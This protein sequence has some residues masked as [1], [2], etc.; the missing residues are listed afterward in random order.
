MDLTLS[1]LEDAARA[2]DFSG[3]VRVERPDG[4]IAEFASGHAD[5]ANKRANNLTTRFAVAS[6]VKGL[7]ALTVM[8]LVES[9]ELT[10]DATLTSIVGRG[11]LQVDE[12]VTIDHLL[13]HRSGVGDYIDE[14]ADGDVDDHVLD[15]LSVHTLE[16]PRDYLELLNAPEQK[17]RPGEQFAYNNS[18]FV[19]LSLVIEAI[20][21]SYHEAVNERV[22]APAGMATAAFL[23]TDDLPANTALG[24]LEDGRT[25][26]FHLPVI[27]AGDGGI[28][29]T[30]DDTSTFW[31]AFFDGRIVSRES[32]EAMTTVISVYNDKRSYGRGFWLGQEGGHVWLEGMDPGVSFQSG[33]FRDEGVT[34]SVISNTSSGV[35]PL[36]KL[37]A[38]R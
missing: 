8:S 34:Y 14:E 26:L 21:G 7:T 25:N 5:R 32:A 30:L 2:H 27:G 35:W 20:T 24:Y 9:G 1:E 18:G 17:S 28:Y 16:L 33:C 37:I 29:L 19:M 11:L 15:S 13:T 4:I 23:R 22:L 10:L 31:P 3:A 6:G 36:V 38:T 12:A